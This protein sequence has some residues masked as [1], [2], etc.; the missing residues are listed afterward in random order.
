MLRPR[1]IPCLLVKNNGLVKTIKFA[2]PKYVGDPINAV[3]IF[4]EKEVDELI[5]L[6][7]DATVQNRDPDYSMIKNLAAEC[8]M[9]LCYGGG[10]K[11]VEQV[12]R[13]ISLGVEKVAM[14]SAAV[15]DPRIVA[16][17]AKV[18][19]SQSIAVVMDVKK[20]VRSGKYELWTH[21]AGR[22]GRSVSCRSCK[23]N[24]ESRGRRGCH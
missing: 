2:N 9:P 12:E 11:T 15:Y 7:I 18:V 20:S 10:V 22:H 8:R 16:Q 1:I 13:I 19:G 23:T 5:V 14:S 6:N 21:N 17:A 4:N 3:K 24:G